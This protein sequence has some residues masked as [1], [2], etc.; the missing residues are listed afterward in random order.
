MSARD[1]A[2]ESPEQRLARLRAGVLETE[3]VVDAARHAGRNI[4]GHDRNGVWHDLE[5]ECAA[6]RRFLGMP[7]RYGTPAA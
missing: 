7:E 2:A 5:E 1:K 4:R 6:M 3:R